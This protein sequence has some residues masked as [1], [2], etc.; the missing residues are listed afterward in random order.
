[1]FVKGFWLISIVGIVPFFPKTA[2]ETAIPFFGEVG[3]ALAF[4]A[5]PV[6][7]GGGLAR[8]VDVFVTTTSPSTVELPVKASRHVYKAIR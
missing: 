8:V 1:M 7:A 6:V 4:N 2:T 3:A 5:V